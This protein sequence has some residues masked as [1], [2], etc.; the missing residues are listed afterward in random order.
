MACL[1]LA[2]R[3]YSPI[4]SGW[5]S[6]PQ[7]DSLRISQGAALPQNNTAQLARLFIDTTTSYVSDN[8]VVHLY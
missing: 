3:A 2:R 7:W 6:L 4:S 5:T 8:L 1:D